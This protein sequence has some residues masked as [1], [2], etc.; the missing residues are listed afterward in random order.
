MQVSDF[1]RV[2]PFGLRGKWPPDHQHVSSSP[3]EIRRE[4]QKMASIDIEKGLAAHRT[5]G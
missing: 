2:R 1:R 4:V 5:C 3:S